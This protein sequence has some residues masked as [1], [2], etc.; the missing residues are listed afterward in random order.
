MLEARQLGRGAKQIKQ[1]SPP[2]WRAGESL[3]LPLPA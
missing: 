2:A 3:M 1:K